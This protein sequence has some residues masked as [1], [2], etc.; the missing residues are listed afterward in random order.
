MSS[1]DGL[2]RALFA[3]ENALSDEDMELAKRLAAAL[4]VEA[5]LTLADAAVAARKRVRWLGGQRG[6]S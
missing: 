5:Q 2:K 3:F 4:S 1:I 6:C